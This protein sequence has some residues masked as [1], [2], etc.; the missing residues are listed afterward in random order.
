MAALLQ[1][2]MHLKSYITPI[3]AYK[4]IWKNPIFFC[5]VVVLTVGLSSQ[6][7]NSTTN[8][9]SPSQGSLFTRAYFVSFGLSNPW[10]FIFTK[11]KF[12]LPCFLVPIFSMILDYVAYSITNCR[13]LI[14]SGF[15]VFATLLSFSIIPSFL[16]LMIKISSQVYIECLCCLLS[17]NIIH[18]YCPPSPP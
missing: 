10:N 1:S 2:R 7:D 3:Q 17:Y 12:V 8:W 16:K 9:V 13:F 15:L 11:K 5:L 14:L 18:L 6:Y 4:L